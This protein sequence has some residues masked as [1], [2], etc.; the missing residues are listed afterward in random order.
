MSGM[1]SFVQME[2]RGAKVSNIISCDE[3]PRREEE[4]KVMC[5]KVRTERCI[6]AR[7]RQKWQRESVYSETFFF[8]NFSSFDNPHGYG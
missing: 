7:K 4:I 8:F 6:E 2:L 5:R 1:Q 3:A